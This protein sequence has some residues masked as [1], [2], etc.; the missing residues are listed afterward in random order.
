[1]SGEHKRI[2]LSAP[3]MSGRELGYVHET[4]EA[5]YVAPAG[6]LLN[7]FE[8]VFAT[9]TGIPHTV[10]VSSGTAAIHLA[11]KCIDLAP[12]DEVWASTLTFIG[13]LSPIVHDR[14]TPVFFDSDRASW[15]L[16]PDLLEEAIADA[17]KRNRLPKVVLPTDI[18]GQSCDLDRIL[19]ICGRHGVAVISDSAEAV[20]TRYK[21][22]H[23]GDGAL[24]ACYSFNGNKII[25]TSGG[26]MCAS[27]DAKMIERIRY[28]ST[29]ARQPV[30]H[31]E[32]TEA[33]FNYR[34]SAVCAAIGLGQLE[35]LDERVSRRRAIFDRYRHLL[36]ELP[37]ISFMPEAPYGRGTRWLSV[38]MV[39]AA[40]FGMGHEA[41]RLE[42]EKF[43]IEARPAWKPMHKQ[44]VF[45]NARHVGG[46]VAEQ[47]FRDAI[48]LPSGSSM[49]DGQVDFIAGIIANL[50]A[51]SG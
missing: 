49:T 11:L 13:G 7:R 4:F 17:A 29:Q 37:G 28:L 12:G 9:C 39:D 41:I 46:A 18:Y 32:H 27:H 2:F 24:I 33:G 8:E 42:L 47:I 23:A 25:T 36:G 15:N 10:A 5:N 38:M 20:G 22:R 16:D 26:G 6:P 1:M 51:K 43:N 44:P 35:V 40:Q 30:I 48:C 3:H 31:Y 21:D 34:L 14:L 50:A 45:A 19:E